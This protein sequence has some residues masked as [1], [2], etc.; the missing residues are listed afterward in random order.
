MNSKVGNGIEVKTKRN[1]IALACVMVVIFILGML[2]NYDDF[3]F[4][5]NYRFLFSL[6]F[7]PYLLIVAMTMSEL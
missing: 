1:S 7:L 5:E 4:K 6:F 2:G 3:C